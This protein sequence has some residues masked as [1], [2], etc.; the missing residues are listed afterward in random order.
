VKSDVVK[1]LRVKINSWISS[2]RYPKFQHGYQPTLPVP[3][4]S[5]IIGLM[6][7]AKGT[8][9][10]PEDISFGYIFFSEARGVD[11]E[12]VYE[13]GKGGINVNVLKREILLGCTLYLYTDRCEFQEYFKKPYYQLLLGR[14]TDLAWASE[15]K[16]A[17]LE[18]R[19]HKKLGRTSLPLRSGAAGIVQPLPI[20]FTDSIPREIEKMR[21]FVLSTE[22]FEY[23]DEIYYDAEMNWGIW[24]YERGDFS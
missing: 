20:S 21:P 7:A 15:M 13:I 18:K 4:P 5:T 14:S 8:I 6:S 11:L 17:E 1:L 12:R 19:T 16:I 2:F 9:V 10:K 3:P 24:I 23:K 22:L